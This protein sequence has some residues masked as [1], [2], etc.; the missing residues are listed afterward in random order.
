MKGDI[1][2]R[3]SRPERHP[4]P[5][6]KQVVKHSTI[7][8]CLLLLSAALLVSSRFYPIDARLALLPIGIIVAWFIWSFHILDKYAYTD[9][10]TGRV[11]I[12]DKRGYRAIGEGNTRH[13][14]V[15]FEND[16]IELINE[17]EIPSLIPN[18]DYIQVECTHADTDGVRVIVSHPT[19]SAITN[20]LEGLFE[21]LHEG[22]VYIP[23]SIADRNGRT[24]MTIDFGE[25]QCLATLMSS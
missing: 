7:V 10:D 25:P 13:M 8:K 23:S 12:T 17:T 24:Y 9:M 4:L 20:I 6:H 19:N 15:N 2:V 11:Y 3:E 1:V 22:D 14:M 16:F 5:L 21:F 18:E